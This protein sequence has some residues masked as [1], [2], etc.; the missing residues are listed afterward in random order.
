M[1]ETASFR[2]KTGILNRIRKVAQTERRPLQTQIEIALEQWL[3]QTPPAVSLPAAD[4]ATEA[5][6]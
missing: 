6:K 3:D 2:I 5:A 1:N 4:G